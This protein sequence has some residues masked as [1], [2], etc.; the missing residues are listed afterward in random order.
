MVYDFLYVSVGGEFAFDNLELSSSFVGGVFDEFAVRSICISNSPD[1]VW[2]MVCWPVLCR[3]YVFRDGV[4]WFHCV[5][6]IVLQALLFWVGDGLEVGGSDFS[7]VGVVVA[8]VCLWFVA[9]V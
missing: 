7:S 5:R 9:K 6:F 8:K 4:R 2:S 1:E 3:K